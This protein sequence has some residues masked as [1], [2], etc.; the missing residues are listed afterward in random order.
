MNTKLKYSI[1]GE[2]RWIH[3]VDYSSAVNESLKYKFTTPKLFCRCVPNSK[4]YS[5]A[6]A[7]AFN[8]PPTQPGTAYYE[9]K[10]CNKSC[11]PCQG[12]GV[13]PIPINEILPEEQQGFPKNPQVGAWRSLKD[14]QA[15]VHSNWLSTKCNIWAEEND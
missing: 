11:V 15:I 5:P 9:L 10:I 8:I 2:Y 7:V 3:P 4:Y 6:K 14:Q 12:K 1:K 13:L